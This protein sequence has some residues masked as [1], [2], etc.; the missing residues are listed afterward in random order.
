M[1]WCHRI[2]MSRCDD[3]TEFWSHDVMM[4]RYSAVACQPAGC[5][6]MSAWTSEA[7]VSKRCGDVSE[8]LLCD[9]SMWCGDVSESCCDVNDKCAYV[10]YLCVLKVNETSCA[11]HLRQ[12]LLW[13]L[14]FPDFPGVANLYNFKIML[15][16]VWLTVVFQ[17]ARGMQKNQA[18]YIFLQ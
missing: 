15:L 12:N 4:S 13:S 17:A 14:K 11:L 8:G 3:V 6:V 2:L 9:I 18:E 7:L 5:V 16:W 10:T 1:W